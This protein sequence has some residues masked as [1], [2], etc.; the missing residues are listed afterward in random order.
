MT[1]QRCFMENITMG[2]VYKGRFLLFGRVWKT[3][4]VHNQSESANAFVSSI[5]LRSRLFSLQR[6]LWLISQPLM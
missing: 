5:A 3:Y 6:S 4:V 2:G 1:D